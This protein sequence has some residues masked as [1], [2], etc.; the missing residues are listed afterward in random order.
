LAALSRVSTTAALEAAP[1]GAAAAAGEAGMAAPEETEC[2]AVPKPTAA[3][4]EVAAGAGRFANS[5]VAAAVSG[6]GCCCGGVCAV[7]LL[8][9][10]EGLPNLLEPDFCCDGLHFTDE[11]GEVADEVRIQLQ[12]AVTS[13]FDPEWIIRLPC[14]FPQLLTMWPVHNVIIRPMNN[15]HWAFHLFY[16]LDIFVNVKAE[17]KVHMANNTEAWQYSAVENHPAQSRQTGG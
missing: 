5:N 12:V 6:E 8:S 14:Q 17:S 7:G 10:L 15:E 1:A 2:E 3:A 9:G 16:F 13:P 4:T 11:T